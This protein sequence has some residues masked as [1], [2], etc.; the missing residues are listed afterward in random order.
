MA[1]AVILDAGSLG[2]NVDL[3]P[4]TRLPFTWKIHHHTQPH[5][6]IERIEEATVVLSN[7]VCLRE[8]HLMVAKS[9]KMIAVLATGTNNIDLKTAHDRGILV[10]NARN[11]STESVVE[12]TLRLMM[13]LA[14]NLSA[15]QKDVKEGAWSLTPFFCLL[16]HPIVELR[17]RLLTIV[18]YGH[19]GQRLKTIAQ[20]LGMNVEIA[21][22]PGHPS[23]EQRRPL[24]EL[25]PL[26]DVL[27]FHC[28]LTPETENLL[29]RTNIFKLKKG[30]FVINCARGGIVN[31]EALVEVLNEGHLGGA[32]IDVLSVEPPPPSHPFWG[33]KHP[34]FIVTPHMAWGSQTSRQKLVEETATNITSFLSGSHRNQV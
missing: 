7:K 23:S 12:H 28:P 26:T 29:N 13:A 6:V 11:Y 22:R 27:S 25:L 18:G 14:G 5:E 19:Q 10:S 9:L 21:A 34:N 4:L 16:S 31:E 32:G 24:E 33:V 2:E 1:K 30:A 3:S 17:R 8:T 20:A 15:Y